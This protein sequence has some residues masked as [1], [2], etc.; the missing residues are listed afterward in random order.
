MGTL[1]VQYKEGLSITFKYDFHRTTFQ[2]T[3]GIVTPDGLDLQ[4]ID[5]LLDKDI[6][7]LAE[8]EIDTEGC[9]FNWPPKWDYVEQVALKAANCPAR[10]FTQHRVVLSLGVPEV[11]PLF[12]RC[13]NLRRV[14]LC[15]VTDV[16]TMKNVLETR[17]LDQVTCLWREHVLA[18]PT[19]FSH[20][21]GG[22]LWAKQQ[23]VVSWQDLQHM[24]VLRLLVIQGLLP[25]QRWR[26]WLT[27]G[28]YDPRLLRKI[29]SFFVPV[30]P[31]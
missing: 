17:R 27:Q 28:L 3:H 18:W 29:A 11:P 9:V 20:I 22:C 19:E 23:G 30:N 1:V 24:H 5:A 14:L 25:N 4:Q 31:I 15:N 12:H 2:D 7:D 21:T 13:T 8:I 16:L 26:K 6:V 10:V